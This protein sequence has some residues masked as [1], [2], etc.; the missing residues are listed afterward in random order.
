MKP[1][2]VSK[3]LVLGQVCE[4]AMMLKAQQTATQVVFVDLIN[5]K[6]IQKAY[7]MIRGGID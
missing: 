2:A 7:L 6:E 5:T 4:S 3:L 1:H